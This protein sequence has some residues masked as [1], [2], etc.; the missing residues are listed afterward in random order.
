MARLWQGGALPAPVKVPDALGVVQ[1]CRAA[2]SRIDAGVISTAL[3]HDSKSEL[4]AADLEYI[5]DEVSSGRSWRFDPRGVAESLYGLQ[6]RADSAAVRAVVAAVAFRLE[7]M[8]AAFSDL[9]VAM[10]LYGLRRQR[11][12]VAARRLMAALVPRVR[13]AGAFSGRSLSQSL[14]GLQSHAASPHFRSM[15]AAILDSSWGSRDRMESSDVAITL[16]GLNKRNSDLETQLLVKHVTARLPRGGQWDARHISN[17]LYGL[18]RHPDASWTLQLCGALQPAIATA[19][20]PC[21]YELACA[22]YGFR[23]RQDSPVARR[24]LESV[25]E[26]GSRSRDNLN[27]Q[28]LGMALY[29]MQGIG[30]TA[31]SR[32]VL[33]VCAPRISGNFGGVAVALSL[34]GLHGMHGTDS[35]RSVVSALVPRVLACKDS[36]TQQHMSMCLRG[37][38]GFPA[39]AE[40]LQLLSWVSRRIDGVRQFAAS[41]ASA[42]VGALVSIACVADVS[43][44]LAAVTRRL[45]SSARGIAAVALTQS[46][47]MLGRT[48]PESYRVTPFDAGPSSFEERALRLLFERVGVRGVRFNVVHSS[49]FELDLVCGKLNIELDGHS[50]RYRSAAKRRQQ[51]L[52]DALLRDR[53]GIEVRRVPTVGRTLREVVGDV[54]TLCGAQFLRGPPAAPWRRLD[55]HAR[56]GW[57]WAHRQAGLLL[58][59]D[60]SDTTLPQWEDRCTDLGPAKTGL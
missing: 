39:S 11:D 30:D 38:S 14:Y 20:S 18:H 53:F 25:C 17:A 7:S 3:C 16:F 42:I 31:A 22:L 2:R 46:F 49:G 6:R 13:T 58:L 59:S 57:G 9:C 26:W 4:T 15:L 24:T 52:R 19:K 35:V 28:S 50:L 47:N 41:A 5:A 44:I 10:S 60:A 23:S 37:M 48:P 56:K 54:A 12:T 43:G 32:S 51:V 36:L 8:N 27:D 1:K 33:S 34:Y 55:H 29:G 40:L 45:P 21:G